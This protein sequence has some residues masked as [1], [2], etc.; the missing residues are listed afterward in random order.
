[1]TISRC[2]LHFFMYRSGGTHPRITGT[3]GCP[4][5]LLGIHCDSIPRHRF[6]IIRKV[7]KRWE[8]HYRAPCLLKSSLPLQLISVGNDL[9]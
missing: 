2:F 7:W 3:A 1:M 6:C 9:A 8:T 5:G 4:E